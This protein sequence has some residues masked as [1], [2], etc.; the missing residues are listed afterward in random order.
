M[1]SCVNVAELLEHLGNIPA[2]RVL[3]KPPPGRATERDVIRFRDRDKRLCELIDGTLVEKTMGYAESYLAAELVRLIGNHVVEND[4]GIVTGADG[5]VRLVQ[6][7][8]RIPDV[9]FVSWKHLPDRVVPRRPIP[10][11][12]PDLAVEVLSEGNTPGEMQRK[13]RD[14]FLAG[15]E[16]V[17]CVDP[18]RRVVDVYTSPDHS[19]TVTE[20]ETL[21]GGAVVPGFAL[22]LASL[23]ARLPEA[24]KK[25]ARRRKSK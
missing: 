10:E 20:K 9:A 4:L 24:E 19:T 13:L 17:W 3:L 15:V 6:G 8:V 7:L 18:E 22:P 25:P 5:M 14:Y 12:A 2:R 23:F 1:L 16:M 11:L 21:T